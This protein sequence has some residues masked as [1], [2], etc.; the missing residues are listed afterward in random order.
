MSFFKFS[1]DTSNK[2]LHWSRASMDG[3]PFKGPS[4]PL[5]KDEEFE[6]LAEKV[7]DTKVGIFDSTDPDHKQHGR[8]YTEVMD[9]I[10]AGWF[11]P[12]CERE[13]KWVEKDG[14]LK[15]MV[16]MEW[17]EPTMQLPKQVVQKLKATI[18]PL[19][20]EVKY[21]QSSGGTKNQPRSL[22]QAG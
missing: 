1:E 10:L 9:G 14:E 15:M 19:E 8:T 11:I 2:D 21:G 3:A 22:R 6:S 5:L 16:Y 13:R 4:I 18:T 20:E 12:L 17:S 7:H